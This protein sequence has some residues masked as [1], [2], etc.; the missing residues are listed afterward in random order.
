MDEQNQ[1]R[2]RVLVSAS[3]QA[4]ISRAVLKWLN[5]Y[6]D[7]PGKR[8][9]FEFL[10]K[11]SGLTLSTIQTAYKTR[12]FINGGY[13]AQ[14]Q[15]QIVYRLI[16]ADINARLEADEAL[17]AMGEWCENNPPE[18]PEGINRWKVR[19]DTGASVMAR[20]DNNAEDHSIT[21]TLIYE[22]I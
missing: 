9:D 5:S 3:E 7:K 18:L 22:V 4:D 2:T 12:Q 11:T 19:R 17:D 21:L 20:Y 6:E 14:Y 15:F 8:V 16:A 10:G 13:Q 1:N